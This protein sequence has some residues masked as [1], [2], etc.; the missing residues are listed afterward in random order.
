MM[1]TISHWASQSPTSGH[2][3]ELH[4]MGGITYYLSPRIGWYMNNALWLFFGGFGVFFL[5]GFLA[6]V[7]W[8]RER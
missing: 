7:G 3:S 1:F 2:Y 6:G 5:V 4:M 8:E